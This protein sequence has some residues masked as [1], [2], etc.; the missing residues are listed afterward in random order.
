MINYA[1]E[2]TARLKLWLHLAIAFFI[3]VAFILTIARLANKGS[4]RGRSTS[5]GIPVVSLRSQAV[6]T[7]DTASRPSNRP[8]SLLINIRRITSKDYVVGAPSKRT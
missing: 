6:D 8:S 7:T 4:A 5:Y 3:L 1:V 2:N